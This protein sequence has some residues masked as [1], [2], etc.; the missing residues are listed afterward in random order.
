MH[1]QKNKRGEQVLSGKNPGDLERGVTTYIKRNI[2][3]QL[4]GKYG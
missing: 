3:T 4:L 1:G 2:I